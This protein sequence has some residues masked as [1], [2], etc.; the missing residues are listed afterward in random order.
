MARRSRRRRRTPNTGAHLIQILGLAVLLVMI[1]LFRDQIAG[2]AGDFFDALGS[3]DVQLPE[4]RT[5]A[6]ELG[7]T[8]AGASS[9]SAV[10]DGG[11]R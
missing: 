5:S 3:E 4:E 8:D 6:Q 2:G 1:V 9:G 11:E 7:G 10:R